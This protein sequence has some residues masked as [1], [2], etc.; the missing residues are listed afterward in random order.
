MLAYV[1]TYNAMFDGM[2][3]WRPLAITRYSVEREPPMND[4]KRLRRELEESQADRAKANI[5][6]SDERMRWARERAGLMRVIFQL[7]EALEYKKHH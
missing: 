7:S 5:S 6:L 2:V 1:D 3:P 4:I